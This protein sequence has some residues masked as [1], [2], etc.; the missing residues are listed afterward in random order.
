MKYRVKIEKYKETD[1]SG[2]YD[3]YDTVYEQV[4]EGVDVESTVRFLNSD[5]AKIIEPFPR[6]VMLKKGEKLI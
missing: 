2:A 5:S 6:P 3:R 1:E 4:M